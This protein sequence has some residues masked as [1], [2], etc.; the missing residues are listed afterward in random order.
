MQAQRYNFKK[1]T[2]KNGL[3]FATMGGL[4]QDSKGYMWFANE[5]GGITKFDGKQ[6]VSYT[7][8]DG[9]I[10]NTA[11]YIFEDNQQNLWIGTTQGVSKFDGIKFTN[12]KNIDI[13]TVTIYHIFQ[14][15]AGNIWFSSNGGGLIKYDGKKFIKFTIKNGL[16]T[17][18]IFCALE[19]NESNLWIGTYKKG[20]CKVSANDIS[21]N[22]V[23]CRV[24]TTTDGLSSNSIFCLNQDTKKNIWIG[25]NTS[26]VDIYANGKFHKA[27]FPSDKGTQFIAKII[28]DKRGNTW[29]ASD[30]YGAIKYRNESYT[31]F[32]EKEGLPGK[33]AFSLCEDYEGNIWISVYNFGIAIFKDEAFINFGEKD[34]LKNDKIVCFLQQPDK[35]ILIG[36]NS[37]LYSYVDNKIE[38]ININEVNDKLI[39]AIC[40]DHEN[41]VWLG[42]ENGLIILNGEKKISFKKT[43]EKVDS[44]GIGNVT[45]I[46]KAKNNVMWVSTYGQGIYCFNKG[47]TTHYN[48]KNGLSTNDIFTLFEDRDSGIWIGTFQGGVIKFA[49]NKFTIFKKQQ[50]LTDNSVECITQNSKGILFF[51]TPQ[52]G[53]CCYNGQK[54]Y[55]AANGD[56]ISSNMIKTILADKAGHIWAGTLN[57][58]NQLQITDYFELDKNKIYNDQNGLISNEVTSL[59]MDKDNILWVGTNDGISRFDKSLDFENKTPPKIILAGIRL[60]NVKVNWKKYGFEVDPKTTLPI[61]LDLDNDYNSLT[62]DYKALSSDNGI[63]YQYY[64]EGYSRSWSALTNSTEAAFPNLPSGHEYTFK[65]KAVNSDGVWSDKTIEYKFFIEDPYYFRWWFITSCVI[66]LIVGIVVF[67]NWRTAKLAQEKKVLEDKVEERTLELKDTNGKL[68]V[69]FK[70]IKDSINYAQRIQQ[71]ILPV[72]AKIRQA[73][74]DSFILFKPRDVVSGDFYWFATVEKEGIPYQVIAAADCTG[75]GVPGAFMSMVGNTILNEIVIT[76]KIIEPS[77]ILSQLHHGVRTALKQNENESRDGMDISLCSINSKTN[78]ITYAGANSPIWVLRNDATIEITKATKAAIGGFTDDAQVFQS[79]QMQLQKGE[80]IY[81]FSDGYADQFGGDFGKKLT[82]KKFREAIIS[83]SNKSM[84]DQAYY[85]NN[86]IEIWKGKESQVDDI[87]VIGIKV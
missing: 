5:G 63:Q 53:V 59:F 80:S 42:T 62:F 29:V 61:D 45:Q 48:T 24:Y 72:E 85:L 11:T 57:G 81:L 9:L 44:L 18:D 32:A 27:P 41:N 75:H 87:L 4:M 73:L 65:V 3:P 74:P 43:L 67:I 16:P 37:G 68:S 66:A 50:G 55:A 79:H 40:S 14:D 21:Q 1:I 46:I 15:K 26:G 51:G 19:D 83:M 58:L 12:Y 7:V 47:K 52:G 76:K 70:D 22:K 38:Q 8:D 84:E 64:L 69:A 60:S 13:D 39:N 31:V 33:N 28:E 54:F 49:Q 34:G 20:L 86:L 17:N 30:N 25:T 78:A 36:T 56:L 6:F 23:N 71:A 82:T 77:E 10:N 35:S 2:P